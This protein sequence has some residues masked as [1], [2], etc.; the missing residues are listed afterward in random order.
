MGVDVPLPSRTREE[1]GGL[2]PD[3]PLAAQPPEGYVPFQLLEEPP[4]AEDALEYVP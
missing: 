3:A 2:C 1:E 4:A